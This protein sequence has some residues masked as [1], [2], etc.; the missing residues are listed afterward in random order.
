[1]VTYSENWKTSNT[2]FS[3]FMPFAWDGFTSSPLSLQNE[4]FFLATWC[5]S[6]SSFSLLNQNLQI[7]CKTVFITTLA[8]ENMELSQTEKNV[9]DR[10]YRSFCDGLSH[11]NSPLLIII[12]SLLQNN[13]N[14]EWN[15]LSHFFHYSLHNF[16]MFL[17]AIDFTPTDLQK[18]WFDFNL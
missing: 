13:N 11:P 7:N 2:N 15:S 12:I 9:Q 17:F 16:L 5:F 8:N 6:K 14:R 18:E 4:I 10:H 1:M 3:I